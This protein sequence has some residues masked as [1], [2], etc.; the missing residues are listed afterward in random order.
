MDVRELKMDCG[1]RTKRGY[2]IKIEVT[3]DGLIAT[4]YVEMISEYCSLKDLNSIF[5]FIPDELVENTVPIVDPLDIVN[6]LRSHGIS[7]GIDTA[8]IAALAANPEGPPVVVARGVPPILGQD[9][10]IELKFKSEPSSQVPVNNEHKIDWRELTHVPTVKIGDELAIKHFAEIGKPGLTVYGQPIVPVVP[11]DVELKAG[12]GC[13]IVDDTKIIATRNGRPSIIRGKVT[14]LPVLVQEKGVTFSTGNIKFDGDVIIQ[15][16]V[17]DNM[18][19]QA[20]GNINVLGNANN[21]FLIAGGQIVVTRNLIGGSVQAGGINLVHSRYREYWE[22]LAK[23]L[24]DCAGIITKIASYP[25]ICAVA[26]NKGWGF[27]L[28]KLVDTKFRPVLTNV[29][30]LLSG[31][32]DINDVNVGEVFNILNPLLEILITRSR[33]AQTSLGNIL[34]QVSSIR[35]FT[36]GLHSLGLG[37]AKSSFKAYST[38]NARIEVS[39]DISI[40]GPGCYQ[41]YLRA[42]RAVYVYNVVRGGAICSTREIWAKE[43]GSPAGA[44]TLLKV[45]ADGVIKIQTVHPNVTVQVG[46]TRYKFD[47]S[48]S[49]I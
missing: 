9:A 40:L 27:I 16:N 2:N 31:Y 5:N 17:D 22:Q 42:G 35:N 15:G 10:I 47:R 26:E 19:V 6:A 30:C 20:G 34:R 29:K 28:Q 25:Q 43:A 33:N 7:V 46:Q 11:K 14:V 4:G 41:S 3:A 23:D 24:E 38:Q 18:E 44:H 37:K 32:K 1:A 45:Q 8:A 21:A 12:E 49:L 13:Q 48:D 36:N 39:G